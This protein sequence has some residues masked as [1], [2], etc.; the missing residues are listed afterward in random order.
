MYPSVQ[1]QFRAFNE[2]FEGAVHFMYL[3]I[4]GLVTVGVGNLIDPVSAA[5]A[6]PF[7]WKNKPGIKNPGALAS[8]ADITA[9]WTRLKKDQSLAHKGYKACAPI[10]DLELDDAA[11]NNLIAQRLTGNEDYLKRRKWCAGYDSWPADA[12][13]G[14]LSMAWAM[15]P[16]GFEVYHFNT[17]MDAC[18]KM[19]F[20]TA[21]DSC[22]MSEK[23]NPGV[24]PRNVAN[25]QLFSNAAALLAGEKDFNYQ[26]ATL[27]Y[28]QILM[29]PIVITG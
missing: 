26:R 27:Y 3:D 22:H 6:L 29:K 5:T 2:K 11:I 23:G 25:K 15:G 4:K 9:E 14:L 20:D 1:S 19:D 21:A 16:G 10:T 7:R 18:S 8:A 24:A 13:M 28:P 12:Q 17:F